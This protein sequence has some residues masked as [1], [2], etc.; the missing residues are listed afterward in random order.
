MAK[1]LLRYARKNKE[2]RAD[3]TISEFLTYTKPG[4]LLLIGLGIARDAVDAE[5]R[6]F[7]VTAVDTDYASIRE[8]KPE[9]KSIDFRTDFF[10]YAKTA[11]KDSFDVIIDSGFSHTLKKQRVERF[12]HV[13]AKLLKHNGILFVKAYSDADEYAK[14]HCPKRK[15]TTIDGKYFYFFSNEELQAIIR[16]HGYD[17]ISHELIQ[18]ERRSHAIEARLRITKL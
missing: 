11:A 6:G 4:R 13:L 5:K 10:S 2:S 18:C 17:I 16:K 9:S 14:K 7:K 8:A 12:F 3:S 1:G 15:W